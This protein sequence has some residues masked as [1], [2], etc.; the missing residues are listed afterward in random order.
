MS[1]EEPLF[2]ERDRYFN[3]MADA[4]KREMFGPESSETASGKGPDTKMNKIANTSKI[5]RAAGKVKSRK[6]NPKNVLPHKPDAGSDVKPPISEA[7]SL[8]ALIE[9][10]QGKSTDKVFELDNLMRS[11]ENVWR[12]IYAILDLKCEGV[13]IF[14]SDMTL[15]EIAE[16]I[17]MLKIEI[18]KRIED[19]RIET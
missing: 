8:H 7:K 3:A 17:K 15:G 9:E 5:G 2:D 1:T 4:A 6:R 12:Q 19:L 10:I 18:S 11:L 13:E 16:R 14:N